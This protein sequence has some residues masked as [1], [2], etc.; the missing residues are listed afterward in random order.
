MIMLKG[1]WL[2]EAGFNAFP[3]LLRANAFIGDGFSTELIGANPGLH[4]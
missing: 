1:M 2:K 3:F 4:M